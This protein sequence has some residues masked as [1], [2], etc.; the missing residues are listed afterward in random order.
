[1][2]VATLLLAASIGTTLAQD[3]TSSDPAYSADELPFPITTDTPEGDPDYIPP[4]FPIL[5]F[6]KYA[7]NPIL[8]PNPDNEWESAYL[9]SK[10]PQS[11]APRIPSKSLA[12]GQ[13]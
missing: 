4:I 5:P 12:V 10:D 11:N 3:S 7:N 2:F 6:N 1:M 8:E 13:L 9:Y